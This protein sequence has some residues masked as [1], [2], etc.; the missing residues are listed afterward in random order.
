MAAPAPAAID[1]DPAALAG[2][3]RAQF[4]A[5]RRQLLAAQQARASADRSAALMGQRN[6]AG[7]ASQLDVLDVQRQ[8]LSALVDGE[9]APDQALFLLRRLQHDVDLSERF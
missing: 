8:Q 5:A 6:A 3:L 1:F 2:L 4:G 7:A 9:L